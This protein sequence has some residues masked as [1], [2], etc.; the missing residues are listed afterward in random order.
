M[1]SA[2]RC[3]P[4]LSII[5]TCLP[6]LLV[7]CRQQPPNVLHRQLLP[8]SRQSSTRSLR[9]PHDCLSASCWMLGYVDVVLLNASDDLTTSFPKKGAYPMTF[10]AVSVAR[11]SI[12]ANS[13]GTYQ[14]NQ[15]VGAPISQPPCHSK[16]AAFNSFFLRF[17][18]Q[19]ALNPQPYNP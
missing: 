2:P 4:S 5:S 19:K 11:I 16:H 9:A 14:Q 18:Y 15:Q 1:S 13:H 17:I 8:T 3:P 6:P 12:W 10:S 7:H